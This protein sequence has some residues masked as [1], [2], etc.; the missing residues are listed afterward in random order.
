MSPDSKFMKAT[1]NTVL[2]ATV[3]ENYQRFLRGLVQDALETAHET[4]MDP[5]EA[6]ANII[7][8]LHQDAIEML[9]NEI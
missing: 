5:G 1:E 3:G 7:E 8:C 6:L 4:G 9:S 2:N